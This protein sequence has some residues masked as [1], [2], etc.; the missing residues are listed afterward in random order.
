MSESIWT[1]AKGRRG[2]PFYGTG[3]GVC[4]PFP[5]FK[6]TGCVM[7]DIGVANAT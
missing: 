1:G 4:H 2:E 3:L 7:L 6:S 5:R